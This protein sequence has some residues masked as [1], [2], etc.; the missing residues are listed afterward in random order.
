M[1]Q[2][3]NGLL[4]SK[5]EALA[6]LHKHVQEAQEAVTEIRHHL[7]KTKQEVVVLRSLRDQSQAE[8]KMLDLADAANRGQNLGTATTGL[9][10][11]KEEVERQQAE[12]EA[13]RK[14]SP[15]VP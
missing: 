10:K 12:I 8:T 3:D 9:R 6:R 13:R 15:A 4:A 5:Q 1:Q 11:L 2:R 7:E 14:T